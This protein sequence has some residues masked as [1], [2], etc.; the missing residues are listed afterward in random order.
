MFF[1]GEWFLMG[2]CLMDWSLKLGR[3]VGCLVLVGLFNC[4]CVS[5]CYVC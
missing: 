3:E 2:V 5:Q 1:G 4:V